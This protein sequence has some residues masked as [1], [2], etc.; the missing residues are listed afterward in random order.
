MPEH[1]AAQDAAVLR[2]LLPRPGSDLH[3]ALLYLPGARRSPLALLEATRGEIARIPYRASGPE[4]V[5]AKLGWWAEEATLLGSGRE[6]HA[7]TRAIAQEIEAVAPV[8]AGLGALVEGLAALL[9][10]VPHESVAARDAA[11]D[12]T[13]GPLWEAH[14]TLGGATDAARRAARALGVTLEI[15]YAVRDARLASTAG[16]AWT[17][18]ETV[19]RAGAPEVLPDTAAWHARVAA[20]ELP[21]L[22]AALEAR[23][24]ALPRAERGALRSL[25]VL[26]RICAA[27]LAEVEADGAQVW[28]RRTDLTPLRKLW[29]AWRSRFPS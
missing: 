13:H 25:V 5:H 2:E 24:R 15:A 23:E 17:S 22:R 14:A 12:A 11:F 19:D 6:R 29:I 20:A 7:L 4:V 9:G 26:T 3:Y 28:E 8:R 16:L 1:R 27:T 18:V 21:L 10:G